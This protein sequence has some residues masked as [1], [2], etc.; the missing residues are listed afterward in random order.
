MSDSLDVLR[1]FP[2]AVRTKL[3]ED[4]RRLQLGVR[5][6]DSRLMT[7]VGRGV[8]ELRAARRGDQYRAIY[9]IRKAEGIYILHAF[10]K[11]SR[12]TAKHDIET[13]KRRLKDI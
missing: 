13:A 6:L 9:V 5:P 7:T 11:K 12:T 4:I 2:K 3:G 8:R 10:I 1:K